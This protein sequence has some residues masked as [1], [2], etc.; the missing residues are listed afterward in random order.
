MKYTNDVIKFIQENEPKEI[1]FFEVYWGR[2]DALIKGTSEF[3]FTTGIRLIEI[4][5]ADADKVL[6]D[7]LKFQSFVEEEY[8]PEEWGDNLS[9]GHWYSEVIGDPIESLFHNAIIEYKTIVTTDHSIVEY[10]ES[11]APAFEDLLRIEDNVL[12]LKDDNLDHDDYG[13]I[14]SGKYIDLPNMYMNI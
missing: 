9:F 14:I 3:R 6:K 1:I 7:L 5:Q 11:K 12:E 10:I 13:I 4:I 8:D 2:G